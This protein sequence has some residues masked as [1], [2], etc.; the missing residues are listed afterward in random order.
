[1]PMLRFTSQGPG[2]S[3]FRVGGVRGAHTLL[4]RHSAIGTKRKPLF[5]FRTR[6]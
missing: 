2:Q 6:L 3:S 4:F 5:V 1:M